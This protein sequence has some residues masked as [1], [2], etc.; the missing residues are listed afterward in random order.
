[1]DNILLPLILLIAALHQM[2]NVINY[3]SGKASNSLWTG[4]SDF[5]ALC[6]INQWEGLAY[7]SPG[8]CWHQGLLA[9]PHMKTERPSPPRDLHHQP[10]CKVPADLHW[11]FSAFTL[12]LS[13]LSRS[14]SGAVISSCSFTLSISSMVSPAHLFVPTLVAVQLP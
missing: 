13:P 11:L 14:F 6:E 5:Q 9:I 7:I 10:Y 3:D 4:L 8:K 1:M 12:T 2:A